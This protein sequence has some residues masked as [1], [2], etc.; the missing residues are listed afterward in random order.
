M[1]I[2]EYFNNVCFAYYGWQ[3]RMY[4]IQKT[5]LQTGSD[6]ALKI[7]QALGISDTIDNGY[8]SSRNSTIS[9]H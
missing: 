5:R 8:N 7:K 6:E 2:D 3:L 1:L 4:L 9:Y